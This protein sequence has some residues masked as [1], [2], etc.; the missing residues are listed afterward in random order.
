MI[1]ES[2]ELKDQLGLCTVL[3]SNKENLKPLK[4]ILEYHKLI[5]IKVTQMNQG[6]KINRI[7]SWRVNK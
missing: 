7:L 5:D 6:N 3:V 4:A 1:Y 2:I